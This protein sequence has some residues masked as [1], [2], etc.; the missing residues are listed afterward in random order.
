MIVADE[1]ISDDIKNNVF[2]KLIYMKLRGLSFELLR[3]K[4][5]N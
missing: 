3:K 2:G 5:S 1:A 4:P